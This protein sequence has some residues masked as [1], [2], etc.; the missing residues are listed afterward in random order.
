MLEIRETDTF[1]KW[2]RRLTDRKATVKILARI[3]RRRLGN[4]GDVGLVGEGAFTTVPSTASDKSSQATDIDRP[5][6]IAKEED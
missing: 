6:R 4:P 3:D 2:R 5:M 1:P